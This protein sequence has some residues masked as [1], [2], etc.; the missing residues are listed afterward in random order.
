MINQRALIVLTPYE[1][2]RLI[3]KAVVKR[4]AV[5]RAFAQGWIVVATGSTTGY[6]AEELLGHH[7]EKENFISGHITGGETWSTP[8]NPDFIFPIVLHKGERQEMRMEE[9]L[10]QFSHQD[11]FIKGVNAVDPAY[12]TAIMMA[13]QGGGT[14]G[15][16]IGT[17]YARG[18]HLITPVGL[19]KMIASV[20]EA[21]KHAGIGTFHHVTGTAVGLMPL[22]NATVV[23]EIQAFA[24]LFGVKA[25]HVGSGGIAGS[26]G[27]VAIVIEG[28]QDHVAEAFAF[29]KGIKGEKPLRRPN[30]T[31]RH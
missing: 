21:A 28:F 30:G 12:N 5:E 19:E 31:P 22:I 9:A 18:A 10:A 11:V 3:A 24:D 25:W 2:R 20:P 23:T 8:D 16:A 26:E 6:V 14:I 27:S 15:A 17:V 4:P 29:A 1:S 13:H 7:L